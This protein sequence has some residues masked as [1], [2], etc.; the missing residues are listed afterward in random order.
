MLTWKNNFKRFLSRDTKLGNHFALRQWNL[1]IWF[2][3]AKCSPCVN[4]VSTSFFLRPVNFSQSFRMTLHI[5]PNLASEA[6]P[7]KFF[8]R[9]PPTFSKCSSSV[10]PIISNTATRV[11]D[12]F[13][14][15]INSI[16]Q[17][18]VWM[19]TDFKVQVQQ[20][21]YRGMTDSDWSTGQSERNIIGQGR[22]QFQCQQNLIG[23]YQLQLPE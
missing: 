18:R 23:W 16:F 21:I 7:L 10:S 17:V 5:F 11:I 9:K 3:M 20:F 4:Q 15:I 22:L 12:I 14:K 19:K 8:P 6:N 13:A 2:F 1:A